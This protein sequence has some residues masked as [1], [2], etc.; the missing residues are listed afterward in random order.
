MEVEEDGDVIEESFVAINKELDIGIKQEEIPQDIS[1][2][3]IK[4]EPD[5]VSYDCVCLLLD[6]F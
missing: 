1:F 6:T 2:P 5:E 3:G 4:A